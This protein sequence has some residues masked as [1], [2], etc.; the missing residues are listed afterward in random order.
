MQHATM[1]MITISAHRVLHV[2]AV[3]TLAVL[4]IACSL[5]FLDLDGVDKLHAHIPEQIRPFRPLLIRTANFMLSPLGKALFPLEAA[6]MIQS[7][8]KSI[9]SDAVQAS[10]YCFLD[11]PQEEDGWREALET[12]LEALNNEAELTFFG[13]FFANA[14]VG[15]AVLQRARLGSFWRAHNIS[16]PTS[17]ESDSHRVRRPIFIV[18]LPRTGTTMLQELLSQDPRHR[19]PETWELMEPVPPPPCPIRVM[20]ESKDD[21]NAESRDNKETSARILRVQTDIDHY[22]QLAPGIDSFHPIFARRPEECILTMA[23]TFDSQ[24]YAAT[25]NIPSYVAS[26]L[27]N[28]K[29]HARAMSW[30]RRVMETIAMGCRD[31]GQEATR[32]VMKT[33]YYLTLLDDVRRAYPDATIVQTHRDPEEVLA[34]SA[35]VHA[36]TY[37]IVSDHLDLRMIGRQQVEMQKHF[38]SKAMATRQK[39]SD[40]DGKVDA[41]SVID[42]HLRDL[43]SDPMATVRRLYA[44]MGDE[45][46]NEAVVAMK[47]WLGNN[48]RTKHGKH[49]VDKEDFGLDDSA[50]KRDPV[51]QKYKDLFGTKRAKEMK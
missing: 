5:H 8:C 13:R 21:A 27:V 25:Y 40:D 10:G 23:S 28:V 7:A 11:D 42:V 15:N 43:Q 20:K 6:G 16:I 18:G 41:F 32:W 44:E 31:D 45:L 48:K 3:C 2:L 17:P 38:L 26:V 33:P 39:W 12:L 49:K 22:K 37:G 4:S 19:A 47:M 35:S 29:D 9:E 51:L 36:K 14:A 46:T 1:A 30:H 50:L 24:Q 34:S